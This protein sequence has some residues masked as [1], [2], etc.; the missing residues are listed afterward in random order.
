[1]YFNI[2]HMIGAGKIGLISAKSI[3]LMDSYITASYTHDPPFH[4]DKV[5]VSY[6]ARSA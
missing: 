6:M 2:R 3:L 1:M 5:A 4:T